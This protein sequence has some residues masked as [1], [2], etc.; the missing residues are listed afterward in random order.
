MSWFRSFRGSFG[1]LFFAIKKGMVI[2][3]TRKFDPEFD[4]EFEFKVKFLTKKIY[5][6]RQMGYICPKGLRQWITI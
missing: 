5:C 3:K 1:A 2:Q 4:P 6:P